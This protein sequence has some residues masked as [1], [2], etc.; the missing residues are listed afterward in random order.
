MT[1]YITVTK[2]NEYVRR[3][4]EE[5]ILLSGLAVCGE[6]ITEQAVKCFEYY[7]IKKV[8]VVK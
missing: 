2:L 8:K 6:I 3:Y 7:G 4:M 5:N 1:D